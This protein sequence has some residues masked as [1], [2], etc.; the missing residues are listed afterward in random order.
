MLKVLFVDDEP[1]MLEGLR[2]MLD[3]KA[4]GFNICGEATNGVDALEIIKMSNPDLIITDIRMPKM[5]GLELIRL[6]YEKL[7]STAKI[8]ILSGYDDFGYAKQA[9][10]YKIKDYLLKPLDDEELKNVVSK[11]STEILAERRKAENINVQ[12]TFITNQCLQRL[13]NGE[14][15]NSLIDRTR[16][17]LNLNEEA[18]Y[19]CVMFYIDTL[20]G[21]AKNL[22]KIN[23]GIRRKE[24]VELIKSELGTEY[25]YNLFEDNEDRLCM[26]ISENM[27]FYENFKA[28]LS[29]LQ[30][31]LEVLT[32]SSVALAYSNPANE[33]KTLCELY[34]QASYAINFKFYLGENSII[35]YNDVEDKKLNY[36]V[37]TPEYNNLLYYIRTNDCSQI[38]TTVELI[39]EQFSKSNSAPEIIIAY[40]NNFLLELVKVIQEFDGVSQDTMQ[41]VLEFDNFLGYPSF[42][43][44]SEAFLERC[45]YAANYIDNLKKSDS[46]Y[47]IYEIKN[48]INENY[49]Q[50]IKLKKVASLFFMNPVYL[51]QLFKKATGMQFNDYLNYV[52]IEEA[53][54]LLRQTNM[55]VVEISKVVGYKDPKYFVQKFKSTTNIS[56]SSFKSCN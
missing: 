46:Q 43:K 36:Q 6:V 9:M 1:Y 53:K 54:K 38:K 4:F 27:M 18:E 17:L 40:V 16:M 5:D 50:D 39:F 34:R 22:G 14:N 2:V 26:I 42:V 49:H 35:S 3:W 20:N 29:S 28:F 30:K 24:A 21:L 8:V 12:L 33:L 44:L 10:M 55:K 45:Y 25:Q 51:G 41:G 37:I 7:H 15:K 32:G 47:I 48:Y 52:R 23:A 19:R 31:K 56:P 13:L 11:L